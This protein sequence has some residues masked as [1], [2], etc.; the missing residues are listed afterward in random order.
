MKFLKC[1]F[2]VIFTIIL[3]I[4]LMIVPYVI[5]FNNTVISAD[6]MSN[7]IAQSKISSDIKDILDKSINENLDLV[8]KNLK[9][10][11]GTNKVSNQ[12]V[13][14]VKE[15]ITSVLENFNTEENIN[16]FLRE[17]LTVSYESENFQI[18]D[19]VKNNID[20]IIKENDINLA[21]E[22]KNEINDFIDEVAVELNKQIVE[23]F[24][25]QITLDE[26][27]QIVNPLPTYINRIKSVQ[28]I[29][30][31]AIVVLI[32]IILLI[33]FKSLF[34]IKSM[35]IGT[36]ISGVSILS[37]N[38]VLNTVQEEI[39]RTDNLT[40]MINL[41]QN[42]LANII[43]TSNIFGIIYI[44]ISIIT[45]ITV[46]IIKQKMLKKVENNIE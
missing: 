31:I 22:T 30:I 28:K 45:I 44:V 37:C 26:N 35:A 36:L 13:N 15:E 10:K 27:N 39:F 41:I 4:L 5:G 18:N 9:D 23:S 34:G 12:K 20:K 33:N 25:G 24:D 3:T 46:T 2:T 16:L 29:I 11:L 6:G 43:K 14:E 8:E 1:F 19:V 7:F 38:F 32:V 40:S 21:E 17:I 42:I